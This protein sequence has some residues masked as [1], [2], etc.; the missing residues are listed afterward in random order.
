MIALQNIHVFF[1]E[2]RYSEGAIWLK[3]ETIKFSAPKKFQNQKAD[4]FIKSNKKH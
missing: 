4:E 3:D 2:L 1:N